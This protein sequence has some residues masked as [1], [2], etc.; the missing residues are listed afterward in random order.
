MRPA[1]SKE[2]FM[3][4]KR[5]FIILFLLTVAMLAAAKFVV[6]LPA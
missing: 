5:I 4:T 2:P 3:D 6:S 1:K